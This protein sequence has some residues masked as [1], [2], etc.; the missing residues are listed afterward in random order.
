MVDPRKEPIC[1]SVAACAFYF[2]NSVDDDWNE[3]QQRY[4]KKNVRDI[5]V[6]TLLIPQ[7]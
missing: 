1:G 7:L 6:K 2:K 5:Y 3:F 4:T